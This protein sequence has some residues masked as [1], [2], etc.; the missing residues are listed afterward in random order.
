MPYDREVVDELIE[1]SYDNMEMRHQMRDEA[2]ENSLTT[3]PE[4][5]GISASDSLYNIVNVNNN[6]TVHVY[7][8][9][10]FGIMD[11]GSYVTYGTNPLEEENKELK[12]KIKLYKELFKDVIL[13]LMHVLDKVPNLNE[14]QKIL[15]TEEI[16]DMINDEC[17]YRDLEL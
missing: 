17:T 8:N 5:H 4:I 14:A 16:N 10:D 13:H 11:R 7:T 9:S 12:K 1:R 6:D 15:I 2:I 3:S